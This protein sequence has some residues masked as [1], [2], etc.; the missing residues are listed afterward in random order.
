MAAKGRMA[1]AA[2]LV[3]LRLRD[4]GTLNT[5]RCEN[6]HQSCAF[7]VLAG[8]F[9]R[10]VST[11]ATLEAL[12]RRSACLSPRADLQDLIK[13]DKE[14]IRPDRSAEGHLHKTLTEVITVAL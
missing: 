2:A 11:S 10:Q 3:P 12:Q 1:A 7:L 9:G 5:Q 4:R 6:L 13:V 14:S 8:A